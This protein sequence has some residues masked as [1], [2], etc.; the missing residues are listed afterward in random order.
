MLLGLTGLTEARTL[1]T[2]PVEARVTP[3]A[4]TIHR[5]CCDVLYTGSRNASVTIGIRS[6]AGAAV[7]DFAPISLDPQEGTSRCVT[8][9]AT[10]AYCQFEVEGSD[11]FYRALAIY[12]AGG[13]Y[14]ISLP[15]R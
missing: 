7:V 2:S 1:Y 14:R 9:A 4:S 12:D 10:A 3:A 13:P 6:R 8:G 15:A 11:R 5:L